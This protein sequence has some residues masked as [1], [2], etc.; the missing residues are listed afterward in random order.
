MILSRASVFWSQV[1]EPAIWDAIGV[2]VWITSA[3]KTKI[4]FVNESGNVERRPFF[5]GQ[6]LS[7]KLR[8]FVVDQRQVLSGGLGLQGAS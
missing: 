3:E 2:A 7:C 8:Y 6:L 4:G 1:V 5:R